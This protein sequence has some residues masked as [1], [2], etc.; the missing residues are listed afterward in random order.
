M[1]DI[2]FHIRTYGCQMN[3]RD[4]E[5]LGCLLEERG[6]T[7]AGSE[8][9]ADVLLFNT[10]SVR[11]Q[12]ERKAVGKIG[13][14]K[15]VKKNKPD[16]VIG[17]L[18]CM[19]QNKGADLLKQLPHVDLVVGTDR[20]HELP[21]L[22][23]R[24]LE[25]RGKIVRTDTGAEVLGALSQHHHGR[26][27]SFVSVMRGCDQ[28]CAYCIV[29]YVRGREKSRPIDDIVAEVR[30]VVENGTKE[31]FLLGQ[32]VTAYGLAELRA[33]GGLTGAES[34][35]G[36]LLR[37]V[38][39]VHGVERVRFTSPHPKYMNEAFIDSVA[40]LPKVCEAFHV[41]MQSGS[42][43]MLK[44]MRRGYTAADYMSR[45]QTLKE[46]LPHATFSTDVIVG[47]PGETEEDFNAT[48]QA[49]ETVGFDMAYIFKY[50]P[51]VGTRAADWADDVPTEVKE[52]R[53]QTLLADLEKRTTRTN[54]AYLNTCVEVLVEG[55]SKRNAATWTGRTRTNKVCIFPPSA[56]V[57][58]GDVVTMRV[59]RVTANSLFGEITV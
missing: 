31:I 50:S 19:A 24:V 23:E 33:T 39:D 55:E 48:R 11:D 21:A 44:A 22:I 3:E 1:R 56:D 32:N 36:D 37:A 7:P 47:F 9:S 38:N 58:P 18:G 52:Q 27:T 2:T 15:K 43:R 45:I 34:P 41:P 13:F 12:A 54:K 30:H 17:V 6:W 20:I 4:S 26:V 5:A 29:P 53:N 10:C 42:D 8:E 16:I 49:M 40:S 51:R 59:D 25:E 35:F 57:K 14:M 28:F 46:R